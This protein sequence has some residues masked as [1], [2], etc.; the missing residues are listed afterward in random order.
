MANKT[1]ADILA[2]IYQYLPQVNQTSKATLLNNLID[3][4]AEEISNRHNFRAL[5]ASSPDTAAMTAGQYYVDMTAFATMGGTAGY[6][7]DI[8]EMRLMKTGDSTYGVIKYL[9]DKEF[10]DRFGYVD[11]ASA[12]R[13]APSYYTRL[14]DRLIFNCPADQAYIA[15]AWY[16]KYHAPFSTD[17]MSHQFESKS[18]MAAFHA[19]VY[20][21]LLEAKS[22]MNAVEFPEELQSVGQMAEAWVQKLIMRDMDVGNEDFEMGIMED[23]GGDSTVNPYSWV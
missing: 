22:S 4:A 15:R 3:V 13:G 2:Q 18:N 1:R 14:G 16:Q 21:T 20:M 6:L 19:L 5:R 7:K 11:Y 10:H 23:S 17:T 8:L 9:D 12:S